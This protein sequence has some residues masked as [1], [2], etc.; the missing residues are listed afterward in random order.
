[1]GFE[2]LKLRW[3]I[4]LISLLTAPVLISFELLSCSSAPC[5]ESTPLPAYDAKNQGDE[6]SRPHQEFLPRQLS[7]S[8]GF[9]VFFNT[10]FD[11]KIKII[12]KNHGNRICTVEGISFLQPLVEG[13]ASVP[14]PSASVPLQLV[15]L[16]PLGYPLHWNRAIALRY[17]RKPVWDSPAITGI[18]ECLVPN[19]VIV[20]IGQKV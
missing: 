12:H 9:T 1:M 14:R 7:V 11:W 17:S 10:I 13:L 5:W 19:T 15:C 6:Q 2:I 20:N 18:T 8:C 4:V 16:C 3:S